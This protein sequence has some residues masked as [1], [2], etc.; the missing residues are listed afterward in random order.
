MDNLDPYLDRF[1]E[2]GRRILESAR[3]ETRRRE[4][5]CISPERILF[6][7][8]TEESDLFNQVMQTFS[9]DPPSVRTAVEKRL[10]NSRRHTGTGLRIAPDTTDVF[11]HSMDRARSEGRTIVDAKDLCLA[12][13]TD[14]RDL[15]VDI[16]QNPEGHN[17]AFGNFR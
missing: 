14:K 8:M 11:R 9:I 2:S 5:N 13:V 3:N 17:P 16:L 12:F 4:Q 1:S 10:E 15:L 6:V 7:L